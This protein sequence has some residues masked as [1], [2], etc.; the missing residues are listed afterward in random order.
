MPFISDYFV[1]QK[2]GSAARNTRQNPNGNRRGYECPEE[3]DYYP[4]WHG[5]PWKVLST[6]SMTMNLFS[7]LHYIHM[8]QDTTFNQC[9]NI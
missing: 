3:R 9:T 4:Y 2:V 6:M 7:N 8:V 1:L 5:S